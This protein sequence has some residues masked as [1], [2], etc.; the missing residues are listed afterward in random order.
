M[1]IALVVA[2]GILL[3][4]ALTA[5]TSVWASGVRVLSLISAPF[6]IHAIWDELTDTHSLDGASDVSRVVFTD[7]ECESCI[8]AWRAQ[9]DLRALSVRHLPLPGNPVSRLAA[10][11]VVCAGE[12]QRL[13]AMHQQLIRLPQRWRFDGDIAREAT[14]A[15]VAD[16][17]KFEACMTSKNT[18][19]KLSADSLLAA[20]LG[21]NAVPTVVSRFAVRVGRF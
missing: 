4:G 7:Y 11:G 5:R 3:G 18:E 14:L 9:T 20:R 6:R 15:A 8:N 1:W 17:A 19:R 21:I 12:Q 16:R 2:C 10:Q 13:L